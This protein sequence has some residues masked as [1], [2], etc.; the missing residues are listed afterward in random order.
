MTLAVPNLE[1]LKLRE[2]EIGSKTCVMTEGHFVLGTTVAETIACKRAVI[3]G[4]MKSVAVWTPD[5]L[6]D[7]V[8]I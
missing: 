6:Q 3:N 1:P 2:G 8:M 5:E 4:N 7:R